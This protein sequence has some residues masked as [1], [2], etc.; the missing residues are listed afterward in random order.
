MSVKHVKI[1]LLLLTVVIVSTSIILFDTI[2]SKTQS[3]SAVKPPETVDPQPNQIVRPVG[4]AIGQRLKRPV[5]R[6]ISERNS[7]KIRE[8]IRNSLNRELTRE[9][10]IHLNLSDKNKIRLNYA[11][12][13]Y[14]GTACRL[15]I[16]TTEKL[17][18]AQEKLTGTVL[19]KSETSLGTGITGYFVDG[20][21]GAN[22]SD[23][24][25]SWDQN[26]SRYTLGLKASKKETLVEMANELG[27]NGL[28]ELVEPM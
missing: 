23:A 10:T 13:C 3:A 26:G 4:P 27:E 18:Q 16:I 19:E 2:T 6:A 9:S 1:I 5:R 24:T 28:R 21:C 8:I 12:R 17:T 15:G 22:C 11:R 25:I 7:R 20:T 14:G